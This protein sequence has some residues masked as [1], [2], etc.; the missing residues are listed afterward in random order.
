M[1]IAGWLPCAE[2]ISACARRRLAGCWGRAS[3]GPALLSC[4]LA[5][6]AWRFTH[7]IGRP[8]T[9]LGAARRQVMAWTL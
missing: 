6:N 1:A 4:L 5:A 2:L 9:L 7:L 3:S 8:Q